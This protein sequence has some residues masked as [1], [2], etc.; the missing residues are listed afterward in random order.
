[1]SEIF[2]NKEYEKA[3]NIIKSKS[4]FSYYVLCQLTFQRLDEIGTMA[5]DVKNKL[6]LYNKEWISKLSTFELASVIEHE[7]CHLFDMDYIRQ[8][9]KN[10]DVFNIA[11]D[12]IINGQLALQ[13]WNVSRGI[14]YWT[15]ASIFQKYKIFID[16][17]TKYSKEDL[18]EILM[19]ELE[20]G[21]N[22]KGSGEGGK[23]EGEKETEKDKEMK[24]A[25]ETLKKVMA[26]VTT[27]KRNEIIENNYDYESVKGM[28][29][30]A[31]THVDIHKDLPNEV[32]IIRDYIRRLFTIF[33]LPELLNNEFNNALRERQS[34]NTKHIY[35]HHLKKHLPYY[36]GRVRNVILAIDT[37]GSISRDMASKFLK[38]ATELAK[39]KD[40]NIYFIECDEEIL[41][42]SKIRS[43]EDIKKV[44]ILRGSGGTSFI[45]VFDLALREHLHTTVLVYFTDLNGLYPQRTQFPFKV[46]WV[47]EDKTLKT[48]DKSLIQLAKRIGK[49]ITFSSMDNEKVEEMKE[50][51]VF[52]F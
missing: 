51:E 2:M 22:I 39:R 24:K 49:I 20:K 16:N 4:P 28:S 23:G 3:L 45:P 11:S 15:F 38:I 26:E 30:N 13:G 44:G 27:D 17:Y 34:W 43:Y 52:K 6:L 7:L 31:I 14:S 35:S 5:I 32:K 10:V 21:E 41:H 9:G 1:M 18:Y 46:Y 42:Y 25:L 40:V 37:S 47:V 8:K 50:H 48:I 36:N 19:K 33:N 29:L 12:I